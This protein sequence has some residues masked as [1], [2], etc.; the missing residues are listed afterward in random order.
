MLRFLKKN[1][2]SCTCI[3][4]AQL[5]LT[6]HRV[7]DLRCLGRRRSA[8]RSARSA[9]AGDR[10][11]WQRAASAFV[12]SASECRS[13]PPA[14][15]RTSIAPQ[16]TSTS[17]TEQPSSPISLM[18]RLTRSRFLIKMRLRTQCQVKLEL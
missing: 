14:Q 15:P 16:P 1:K 7:C 10:S 6:Y 18:S 4:G 5:T 9:R 11:A 12:R 2:F 13:S 17:F 3:V 8:E